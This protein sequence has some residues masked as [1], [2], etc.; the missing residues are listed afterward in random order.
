MARLVSFR[1]ASSFKS[2]C[3]S[4]L[5]ESLMHPA[6]PPPSTTPSLRGLVEFP[7]LTEPLVQ[8]TLWPFRPQLSASLK[9]TAKMPPAF[10]YAPLREDGYGARVSGWWR[11]M[12]ELSARGR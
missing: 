9:P 5:N 6:T 1:L 2:E 7:N 11:V 3:R 8:P 12:N 4:V 10:R